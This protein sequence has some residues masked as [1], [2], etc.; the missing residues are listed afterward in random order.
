MNHVESDTAK[1]DSAR[2][3]ALI[4]A[5]RHSLHMTLQ[6]LGQSSGVSVGYLSQVERDQATPSLGTL[7]AVA[8]SLGVGVDYFIA[9][10]STQDALTRGGERIR[11]SVNESP[12][13]YE[14]LHTE[15][16]GSQL[17]SFLIIIDPGYRSETA[18]HEGEEI[19]FV[20]EGELRLW[21]DEEEMTVRRGDSL[22]F[23]GNRLHRWANETESPVRLLW[24][25]TLTMFRSTPTGSTFQ[26]LVAS[27]IDR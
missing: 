26:G 21:L 3:G 15:F 4:R 18:S 8:K 19:I 17:S 27:Q 7:G 10:P 13:S 6:E 11:F 24:S 20:L 2:V 23:R 1:L 25:G 12:I 5:R 16:P 9:A 14:R 22:H